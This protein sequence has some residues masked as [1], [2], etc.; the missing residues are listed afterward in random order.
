M[1]EVRSTPVAGSSILNPCSWKLQ[2]LRT[3]VAESSILNTGALYTPEV[4]RTERDG[5]FDETV[6]DVIPDH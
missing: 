4:A 6:K 1:S 5:R 2:G 3:P